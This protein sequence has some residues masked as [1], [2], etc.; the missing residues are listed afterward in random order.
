MSNTAGGDY[1]WRFIDRSNLIFHGT[2]WTMIHKVHLKMGFK[3]S[4]NS[5]FLM[6]KFN[7]IEN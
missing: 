5:I 7:S 6:E 1:D 4:D 3:N 2:D